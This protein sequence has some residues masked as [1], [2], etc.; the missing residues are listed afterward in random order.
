MKYSMKIEVLIPGLSKSDVIVMTGNSY[1]R[2]CYLLSD[3]IRSADY[4]V[5]FGEPVIAEERE[6]GQALPS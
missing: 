2:K 3:M 4:S 1:D 5:A 6:V